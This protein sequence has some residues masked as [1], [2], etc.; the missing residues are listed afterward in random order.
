MELS[1]KIDIDIS[2]DVSL[3]NTKRIFFGII[4]LAIVL[5]LWGIWHGYP[6]SYYADEAHFVKRALSFGSGDLN[7]HWFHKPAF[8]MYLLF[9][10]YGLFYIFGKMSGLWHS[11]ND[12]AVSYIIN[13]G[14]FY[15][16]G[17]I[18]T[19]VFSIG[20]IIFAFLT[21]KELFNRKTGLIAGILLTLSFG[22][23]VVTKDIKADTPS[24][25][26]TIVSAYF[27]VCYMKEKRVKHIIYSAVFAGVGTATKYY[28]IVMLFPI[29]I[30]IISNNSN[31]NKKNLTKR[32]KILAISLISF[33]SAYFICS[34]YNFVDPLGRESTF[35]RFYL[36]ASKVNKAFQPLSN[37]TD[38][39]ADFLTEIGNRDKKN[40]DFFQG[41]KAYI[42]KLYEGMGFI[43]F[44]AVCIGFILLLLNLDRTNF[45]FLLF[46]ASFSLLSAF[47]H[48]GYA[49]IRHQIVIYPFM[50][51][52]GS[53]F[54]VKIY[55]IVSSYRFYRWFLLLF[56][57][58]PL[59]QIIN[60]N[61]YI[62]RNDT[63]NL[64][65]KWI[66]SNIQNGT[67]ILID[68]NGPKLLI[69]EKTLIPQLEKAKN[70]DA[71]GQFTAHYENYLRYQL[72]AA[73]DSI[74]YDLTE[75][76]F[77]WWRDSGKVGALHNLTSEYDKDMGNPLRPVGVNSY[78]YYLMNGFEFAVVHSYK[79]TR[80]INETYV[81]KNFPS[82]TKFYREL[83]TKA[84][85][86]KVFSPKNGD[87]PG[88]TVKVFKFR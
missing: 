55:D 33:Y 45:I 7:P 44:S 30:A 9:F 28:S 36:L 84:T 18:T 65:K 14:P 72:L 39:K 1:K 49:D 57:L 71:K 32:V 63:R 15:L 29:F 38:E 79:Y 41:L 37:T 8:Y 42:Y 81:S 51:V 82:F 19:A 73:R 83:F 47:L 34:P 56:A 60:Y 17:R 69:N 22:H 16:I 12:F 24:M 13:P 58:L 59:Y 35:G 88:P 74:T 21:A 78:S 43:I 85:L 11:V 48:P 6:Y 64:A 61:I 25:F 66:E 75:I 52:G 62:S 10:E 27:L 46:P 70:S 40:K 87:R 2:E 68:E 26:F 77:P 4:L 20:S 23:V 31:L 86:V 50:V 53:L 5:R 80:F 67:K 54:F 76:R 3:L